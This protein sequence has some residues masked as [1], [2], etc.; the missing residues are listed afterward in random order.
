MTFTDLRPDAALICAGNVEVPVQV[1]TLAMASKHP[2]F[3]QSNC[4]IGVDDPALH[5]ELV[6]PVL[7]RQLL[8]VP[9]GDVSWHNIGNLYHMS[10][11]YDMEPLRWAIR[12]F[13]SREDTLFDCHPESHGYVLTWL[14]IAERHS[15]QAVKEKCIGFVR[16]W[17]Q[18][19][20]DCF[21]TEYRHTSDLSARTVWGIL[22]GI[23][24]GDDEPTPRRQDPIIP[25]AWDFTASPIVPHGLYVMCPTS[26]QY[27][28]GGD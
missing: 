21:D 7:Q 18:H 6:Y 13:L 17:F 4:R 9:G 3:H 12:D 27:S 23:L 1:N 24:T 22:A 16:F 25:T 14:R 20:P 8:K 10:L 15:W 2:L 28:P 11:K 19:I 5:W 26:P